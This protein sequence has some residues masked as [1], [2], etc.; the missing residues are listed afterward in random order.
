MEATKCSEHE[1]FSPLYPS[2]S[3]SIQK[4]YPQVLVLKGRLC[5]AFCCFMVCLIQF[6]SCPKEAGD[7]HCHQTGEGTVS[8]RW[9]SVCLQPITGAGVLPD[10]CLSQLRDL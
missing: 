2:R 6:R 10:L 4:Y 1:P 5:S 3:L 9:E 7:A 8:S